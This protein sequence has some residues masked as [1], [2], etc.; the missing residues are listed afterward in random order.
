M[1]TAEKGSQVLKHFLKGKEIYFKIISHICSMTIGMLNS[2][3]VMANILSS[4]QSQKEFHI[5]KKLFSN[6]FLSPWESASSPASVFGGQHCPSPSL[7]HLNCQ[8]AD[9]QCQCRL[10]CRAASV[11]HVP[12]DRWFKSPHLFIQLMCSVD[13]TVQLFLLPISL[14]SPIDWASAEWLSMFQLMY[15][16]L[17]LSQGGGL[18]DRGRQRRLQRICAASPSA[19]LFLSTLSKGETQNDRE[20]RKKDK[21]AVEI[22]AQ[23]FA[24]L[25]T[26][27]WHFN[28]IQHLVDLP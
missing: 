23:I 24:T 2:T 9:V 17:Q 12:A 22:K 1:V 27:R 8:S 25:V 7:I 4:D 26:A 20:S 21:R 5:G 15:N 3:Y 6:L 28:G 16:V 18:Y 10:E 19:V 13:L 11:I 14:Y